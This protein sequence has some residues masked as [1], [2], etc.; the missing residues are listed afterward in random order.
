MKIFLES[1]GC[2]R[3]QVD[4]E[5]ML[6]KL[7]AGGHNIVD[8]PSPAEVIIV[9][10]C[11]FIS[12][13][14]DEAIDTILELTKYKKT[15]QC[16][17]L[18]VTGCLVQRYKD[19]P[20]LIAALPEVDA[21][22][23]TG[24]C[25]YIVEAA[26][27]KDVNVDF[28]VD[29]NSVQSVSKQGNPNSYPTTLFP[30][31]LFPDPGHRPFYD[32]SEKR[33]LLNNHYAYVKISEGC[34]RKCTYC[35]IPKLR[36]T[37]RSRPIRDIAQECENLLQ[38]G[39]KEIILTAENSS[40]Y[41]LDMISPDT[42]SSDTSRGIS[43]NKEQ[44][45]AQSFEQL[46]RQFAHVIESN[47]KNFQVAWGRF[48]YGHPE[49][50]TK[51]AIQIV[52]EHPHIC[53]YYDIPIQ[54]ASSDILKKMGRPYKIKEL[55]TLFETIKRSDPAAALRTTIITGFPGESQK[56]F[57][58]LMR[59]IKDIRFDHLGVFVYS[60]SEDI[61]SYG[62]QNKVTDKTAMERHDLIMEAQEKISFEINTKHIG[63][64]YDVLLEENPEPGLYVGR[65]MFQ[66]PEVDGLTFIYAKGL[67]T[68]SVVKVKVNDA[69]EYDIA[70]VPV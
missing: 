34:S 23:G 18:I 7:I 16:R 70:G 1:L 58:I 19:D 43:G 6:G 2:S 62:F 56:D 44:N 28:D 38:R 11:G 13:A 61:K 27:S 54:H 10:T 68:G 50:L 12:S 15:G 59:F 65:T 31:T 26:E 20:E 33:P 52:A 46:L 22:L 37:Q 29:I 60:D 47:N 21:F 66:A 49:S 51:S 32:F 42:S 9:N 30:L 64:S 53:S 39:V 35:I 63:K 40:D 55:Y 3:N 24:A 36:G 45:F 8:A 41:G 14:L 4:S 48:L 67:E 5:I 25:D 57:D 17:R 69:F